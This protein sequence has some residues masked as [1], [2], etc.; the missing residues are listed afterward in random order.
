MIV[1]DTDVL[2]NFFNGRADVVSAVGLIPAAE[3]ALTVVTCEEMLRGWLGEIRKAESRTDRTKLTDAYW[4]LG[5][6]LEALPQFELLPYT[7]EAEA[8]LHRWQIDKVKE[9]RNRQHRAVTVRRARQNVL[10]H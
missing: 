9:V 5:K 6:V 8:L 2:T 7:P 3:L 4:R 10:N 1:L